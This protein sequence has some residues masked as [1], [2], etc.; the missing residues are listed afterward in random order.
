MNKE[1]FE[2]A[3]EKAAEKRFTTV[4]DAIPRLVTEGLTPIDF[5]AIYKS[6]SIPEY[7]IEN[8]NPL[9]HAYPLYKPEDFDKNED[10]AEQVHQLI[11]DTFEGQ[12]VVDLGAGSQHAVDYYIADRAGAKH[13]VGV[14]TSIHDRLIDEIVSVGNQDLIDYLEEN[15]FDYLGPLHESN[16]TPASF[17]IEDMLSFLKRIPDNSVSIFCSGIDR[18]IISDERHR[19]AIAQEIERVL[20]PEGG[21]IGSHSHIKLK[22]LSPKII[23][24][25]SSVSTIFIYKK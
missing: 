2:V 9:M 3:L 19:E 23:D 14:D 21:Y 25:A 10:R 17:V 4:V 15:D 20:H 12:V 24:S 11:R 18:V 5:D 1:Q 16:E 22:T 7:K 8:T 6:E 13:Y